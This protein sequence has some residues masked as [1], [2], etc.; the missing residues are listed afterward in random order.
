MASG[1]RAEASKAGEGGLEPQRDP[2]GSPEEPASVPGKD[3]A[4]AGDAL[5]ILPLDGVPGNGKLLLCSVVT[6]GSWQRGWLTCSPGE[7]G[8]Q[9]HKEDNERSCCQYLIFDACKSATAIL[10]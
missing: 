4:A 3:G 8:A 5:G 1:S 7:E 6:L 2:S 10:R 9:V